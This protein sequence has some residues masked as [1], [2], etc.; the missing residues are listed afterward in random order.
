MNRNVEI[1][2]SVAQEGDKM[3]LGKEID[4]GTVIPRDDG[5]GVARVFEGSL[6]LGSLRECKELKWNKDSDGF[7]YLTLKEIA[8]QAKGRLITVI[9]ISYFNGVVYQY[10][11]YGNTWIIYGELFGFA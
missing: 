10:G 6:I 9:C 3:K 4:N 11:N 1:M 7:E 2:D 8:E 5:N